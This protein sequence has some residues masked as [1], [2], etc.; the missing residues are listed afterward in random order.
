MLTAGVSG[1]PEWERARKVREALAISIDRQ[2]I[3]DELLGGEG[4]PSSQ[5][6]MM[7]HEK[8]AREAGWIWEYDVERAKQLLKEE[9]YED[10][11]EIT[12][13][14]ALR[15]TPSEV[16]VCEAIADMWAD[17]G[18][19][20]SINVLPYRVTRAKFPT[21]QIDAAVCHSSGPYADPINVWQYLWNNKQ[22]YSAGFEHPRFIELQAEVMDT[23]DFDER[24]RLTM[25]LGQLAWDN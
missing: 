24:W 10:G 21:R 8:R 6:G 7:G 2:Q 1:S 22:G 5:W 4:A 18:V 16:E 20:A 9:G 11:F 12:V 19:T 13:V 23:F 25:E 15:N 3:V 17:I 14:P